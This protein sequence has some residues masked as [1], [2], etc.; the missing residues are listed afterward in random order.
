MTRKSLAPI[1]RPAPYTFGVTG[2]FAQL[3]HMLPIAS[4]VPTLEC[5]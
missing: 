2:C 1:T 3:T 5:P 4:A